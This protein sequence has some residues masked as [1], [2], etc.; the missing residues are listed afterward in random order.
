LRLGDIMKETKIAT[1]A[2]L[3]KLNF[4]LL[5]DPALELAYPEYSIITDSINGL[6]TDDMFD[7][8]QAFNKVTI[9]GKVVDHDSIFMDNF[10][11]VIYSSVFDKSQSI[12]SLA[13]DGGN[14]LTFEIQENLLYKGKAS[15]VNGRFEF[16]FIVP[17]DISY[18]IG[19]GKINYYAEN[20]VIDAHGYFEEVMIGGTSDKI[21]SDY[22]GPEIELFMND[23]NFRNGGMTNN[24]PILIADIWDENGINTIGNGIGHDIIGILD[25]YSTQPIILNDYYQGDQDSYMSGKIN[26][27]L[28][29]I[30]PGEHKLKVKIWDVLNNSSEKTIE[31][32]VVG[33][34][35]LVLDKVYNYPNPVVE[36]TNFQFEHNIPGSELNI[37]IDIFDLSGK[38]IRTI[39]LQDYSYGYRSEPIEWDTRDRYGNKVPR[40]IYPY[41]IKIETHEGLHAEKF[42]KLVILN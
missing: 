37:T 26:Y 8:L 2:Q 3:N 42:E 13:N 33:S 23:E 30:E 17:K 9:T 6:S 19:N 15:V 38:S 11:G 14:P 31:F 4:T 24:D 20:N 40:G 27:Q 25:D 34:T 5:G 29:N 21:L 7:T 32:Y 28:Y 16:T 36:F 22:T 10:N 35:K 12:T 39:F 41:R 18:S 1:G